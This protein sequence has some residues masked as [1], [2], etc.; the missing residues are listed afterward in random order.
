M[1][2]QLSIGLPLLLLCLVVSGTSHAFG[3]PKSR[4][5]TLAAKQDLRDEVSMVMGKGYIT[6]AERA[7]IL[8]DAKKVLNAEE[9]PAF[10]RALDRLLPP[11]HPTAKRSV[12]VSRLPPPT[13]AHVA[14]SPQQ[15]RNWAARPAAPAPATRTSPSPQSK[16]PTAPALIA[17][18]QAAPLPP[19][20]DPPTDGPVIPTS[21]DEPDG[22]VPRVN[23]R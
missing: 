15:Q 11:P 1:G 8:A 6:P 10:Q 7:E 2:R 19:R 14:P 12:Q 16:P 9:Y 17:P 5:A 4:L 18:Q 21:A 20:R 3:L 13:P 23:L 22:V